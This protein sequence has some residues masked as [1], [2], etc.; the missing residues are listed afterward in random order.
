MGAPAAPQQAWWHCTARQR[1]MGAAAHTAAAA[2][3]RHTPAVSS[4]CCSKRHEHHSR[5]AIAAASDRGEEQGVSGR[6][7][8]A[9][10]RRCSAGRASAPTERPQASVTR[11]RPL[12]A[13]STGEGRPQER[14]SSPAEQPWR[15]VAGGRPCRASL[16]LPVTFGRSTAATQAFEQLG[17]TGGRATPGRGVRYAMSVCG[18][19]LS[20]PDRRG[21]KTRVAGWSCTP[22][23]SFQPALQSLSRL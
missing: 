11:V 16:C 22:R 5:P 9:C 19:L 1:N 14:G 20:D 7:R 3:R 8:S 10:R 2:G 4:S 21:D 12:H 6:R 18:V 17:A 23:R 13:L 15:E